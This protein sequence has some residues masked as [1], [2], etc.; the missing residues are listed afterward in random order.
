MFAVDLD[1][2]PNARASH[3]RLEV[4]HARG[5][6]PAGYYVRATVVPAGATASA[7]LEAADHCRFNRAKALYRSVLGQIAQRRVGTAW[8]LL[9]KVLAG[10]ELD[11]GAVSAHLYRRPSKRQHIFRT[12]AGRPRDH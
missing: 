10:L 4:F 5:P 9:D 1:L 11:L 3:L 12:F 8:T 6:E 2:R 7:L